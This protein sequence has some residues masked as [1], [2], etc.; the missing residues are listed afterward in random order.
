MTIITAILIAIVVLRALGLE[1]EAR[2]AA[3][4]AKRQQILDDYAPEALESLD[5][6]LEEL[7]RSQESG[8]SG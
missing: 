3:L 7:R 6:G 8:W 2:E 1:I 4:A 5:L